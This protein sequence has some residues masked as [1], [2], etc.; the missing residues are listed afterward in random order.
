LKW[1]KLIGAYVG[2]GGLA[3]RGVPGRFL[4]A[5]FKPPVEVVEVEGKVE[6]E[7]EKST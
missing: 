1:S 6:G 2:P 3:A 5:G 7:G 4:D